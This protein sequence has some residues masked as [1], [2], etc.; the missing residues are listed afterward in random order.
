MINFIEKIIAF[1]L[2]LSALMLSITAMVLLVFL[3]IHVLT[4]LM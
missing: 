1:T 2:L 3:F 4:S